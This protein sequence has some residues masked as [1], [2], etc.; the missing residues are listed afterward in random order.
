MDDSS[1][2][3]QLASEASNGEASVAETRD[4]DGLGQLLSLKDGDCFVVAD[5]YGDI[6]GGADGLF[7]DDTRLLS[8][9][10]LLIG[11][12]LPSKLGSGVSRDNVIFTFHGCNR[13]LPF[14]GQKATPPGVLHI[15]RRRFLWDRR[16]YE[17]VRIVNHSLDDTILPLAYEFDADFR[18]IFE[19]R[20]IARKARGTTHAP[21][22]GGRGVTFGYTGLD[23]VERRSVIDFSDP[24]GRL[25]GH[26]AE[27]ML[28]LPP[29]G[30]FELYLEV[31][32][33]PADTPSRHRFREAAAKA[34]LAARKRRRRGASIRARGPRF[35]EWL[36]QS[37]ADIALL[38]TDLE[39]G[40]YPYAGIPWFSTPF[41]RDGIITAWQMLWLD[42]SIARGVLTYLAR[43]QAME[44]SSFRDAAP[45]K[46]MHE[47][48]GGEM[49][50]LKEVPFGL[51]YGGVDTT[52][53]F[54]ALAGAYAQR[55]GDL[56]FIRGLW[57]ALTAAIGWLEAYG[58]SNGD[59]FIDYARGE[60]SGLSNQG[61]KD[62]EDSI[63]H[64]NGKF[65]KGPIALVEVQGYAFA[66]WRAMGELGQRLGDERAP[67]WAERAE[68]MRQAVEDKF[69]MEEEGYYGVAIDGDGVLCRPLTSNAGHLLF[70]GLPSA[71]RAERVGQTLLS[72]AF[73]TGWGLRTLA[74]SSVRYNPMSYHN[75]T[76]WP[77]DTAICAA[78]MSRYGH[79]HSASVVLE[80]LFRAASYFDMRLP[81][82]FCGF[83]RAPG[84]PPIAYPVACMPQA[85]AAGSVF[86]VMQ[87]CLG[88]EID[89]WAGE[90]TLTR[91]H[92]P[93]GVDRVALWG[94]E[95]GDERVDIKLGR[96]DSMQTVP[97]VTTS[98]EVLLRRR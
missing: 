31:G 23:E 43:R 68:I 76:V 9:L 18:D 12:K 58:D 1:V 90:I 3:P 64:A 95:V 67:G 57:P 7:D 50:N 29:G 80:H 60:D 71:E 94:L 52:P 85:W 45:G 5:S 10:R 30:K 48:R 51:Y 78:G 13:P 15:E 88:L 46:I 27:F 4:A 34:I 25:T 47:T 40:A 61:W 24:P 11:G 54:V 82:L 17:R 14:M 42:P 97:T 63:F 19:V 49:S 59:G 22:A 41:G 74:S 62:S 32:R 96:T 21:D 81:E 35:N 55:T 86:M 36:R 6:L 79:R 20:G 84:E 73:L 16:L 92:L 69:W 26:R 39:T 65:P 91:P 33:A 37:R 93:Q 72:G 2:A 53:L 70:V 8:R 56:D 75:G 87:A 77:H 44:H 98:H 38:A 83:S 28:S 66:A 89:G